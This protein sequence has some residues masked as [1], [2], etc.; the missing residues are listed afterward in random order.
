MKKRLMKIA[1][2]CDKYFDEGSRP[3]GTTVRKWIEEG[4]L[5]G[6][7]V[8]H[9]YFVDDARYSGQHSNPLVNKVINAA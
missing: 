5:P 9:Q 1:A 2:W 8:G 3:S 4:D 7:R 6:E